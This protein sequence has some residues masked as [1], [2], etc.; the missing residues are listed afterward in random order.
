MDVADL[1]ISKESLKNA[2]GTIDNAKARRIQ[3][4][5]ALGTLSQAEIARLEANAKLQA[6]ADRE[7]NTSAYREYEAATE[8]AKA[9]LARQ[10]VGVDQLT[11]VAKQLQEA[12]ATKYDQLMAQLQSDAR[13]I[14]LVNDAERTD[15]EERELRKMI[16]DNVEGPAAAYGNMND[17]FAIM[18]QLNKRA[19]QNAG[20]S[21]NSGR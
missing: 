11:A 9:V 20:I 17:Y 5:N 2:L 19:L 4:M 21:L 13:Y 16:V 1:D 12:Y 14:E 6:E 8:R 15:V 18:D 10:D 7:N 3:A